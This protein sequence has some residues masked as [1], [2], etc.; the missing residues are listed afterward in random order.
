MTPLIHAAASYIS[1][2]RRAMHLK[3]GR[4]ARSSRC[5]DEPVQRARSGRLRACWRSSK[6]GSGSLF[7]IV[8]AK[9]IVDR[10]R[11]RF[12]LLGHLFGGE[13]GAGVWRPMADGRRP[14]ADEPSLPGHGPMAG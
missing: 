5:A 2:S 9:Q 13:R 1:L 10:S 7:V 3:V 14:L 12:H 6:S 11:A 8:L 4:L